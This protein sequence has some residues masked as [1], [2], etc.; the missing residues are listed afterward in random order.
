VGSDKPASVNRREGPAFNVSYRP[1][2]WQTYDIRLIGRDITIVLNGETLF[3]RKEGEG[4]KALATIRTRPSWSDRGPGRSRIDRVPQLHIDAAR[5][6]WRKGANAAL[7]LSP[8]GL[9][10]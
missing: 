2:E 8:M 4:L 6:G 7:S 5:E 1:G 9:P 10:L 3:D